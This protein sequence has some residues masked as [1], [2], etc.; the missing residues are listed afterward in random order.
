MLTN[1][2]F[3][4]WYYLLSI[5]DWDASLVLFSVLLHCLP[6]DCRTTCLTLYDMCDDCI[7]LIES[8]REIKEKTVFW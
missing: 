7:L 2:V 1:D 8:Q 3:K 5:C 6:Y 4:V